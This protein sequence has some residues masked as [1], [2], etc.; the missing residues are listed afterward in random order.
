MSRGHRV[1]YFAIPDGTTIAITA[2]Q[3]WDLPIGS[4]AMKTFSVGG[5]RIETRLF[6]RHDDGGWNP[7]LLDSRK[8]GQ[9]TSVC[10]LSAPYSARRRAPGRLCHAPEVSVPGTT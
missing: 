4:V 5:K 3:D 1:R 2:D 7:S 10:W 9:S 6:M 8:P